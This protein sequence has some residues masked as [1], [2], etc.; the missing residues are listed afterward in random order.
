[1]VVSF[2]VQ[3]SPEHAASAALPEFVTTDLMAR[4]P[5]P[6]IAACC[7]HSMHRNVPKPVS[8]LRR[9]PGHACGAQYNWP[10]ARGNGDALGGA[11]ARLR[12]PPLTMRAGSHLDAHLH[13]QGFSSCTVPLVGPPPFHSTTS[14]AWLQCPRRPLGSHNPVLLSC[15]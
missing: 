13:R 3:Y 12:W 7:I 15:L 4:F 10:S 5:A 9:A 14:E 8:M 6:A 2:D 11:A 1:M